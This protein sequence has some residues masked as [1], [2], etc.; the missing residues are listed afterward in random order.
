MPEPEKTALKQKIRDRMMS[1]EAAELETAKEHYERFLAEARL[2][3][4]EQHDNSDIAEARENAD[5]AAA[6]DHPVKDHHAKID[7]LE[8]LDF[9]LT[10]TIEAGAI[11]GFE[12]R[13]FVVAV[14]TDRF[15]VDGVTYMGISMQSPIYKAM[16]G[17][18]AGDTFTFNGRTV[19]IDEV[20]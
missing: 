11:V 15:D 1:L 20:F 4:R 5:L 6:F 14:S 19:E 2:D 16:N 13:H 3:D 12:G 9:A 7:V 18:G 10:D 17:M 8:S